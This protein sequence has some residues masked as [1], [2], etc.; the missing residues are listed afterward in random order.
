MVR[1]LFH[2]LDPEPEGLPP[3]EAL[4]RLA[5]AVP[6]TPFEGAAYLKHPGVRRYENLVRFHTIAAVKAGWMTK[7]DGTWALTDVGRAAL[8][9]YT[10]GEALYRESGRLYRQWHEQQV[11][12]VPAQPAEA[13][14]AVDVAM[15]SWTLSEALALM[16]RVL[17]APRA[18][19]LLRLLIEEFGSCHQR[20]SGRR[21]A[22]HL[23]FAHGMSW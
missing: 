4:A 9:K 15:I 16:L 21:I 11:K 2:L 1:G 3:K 19:A 8:A 18:K 5:N 7:T 23:T 13:P 22:C 14:K 10:D 20:T 17:P 6:P 12:T